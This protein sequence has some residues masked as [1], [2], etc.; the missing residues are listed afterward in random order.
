MSQNLKLVTPITTFHNEATINNFLEMVEYLVEEGYEKLDS[1]IEQF[2]INTD[3]DIAT[4]KEGQES[5]S[6]H[7]FDL[8]IWKLLERIDTSIDW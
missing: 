3:I 4:E 1:D 7:E 2:L 6:F 5:I 8:A